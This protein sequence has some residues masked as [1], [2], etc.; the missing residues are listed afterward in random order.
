LE[1][2]QQLMG[3]STGNPYRALQSDLSKIQA[4]TRVPRTRMSRQFDDPGRGLTVFRLRI[5]QAAPFFLATVHLPSRLYWDADD[6]ALEATVVASALGQVEQ[7]AGHSRTVVVGD[8]NMNP[9]DAG[10]CG[11]HGLNA[12]MT[13]QVAMREVRVVQNRSYAYFYNPMWGLFGDRTPGPA[14]TFYLSSSKPVNY[15]WHMLDQ[16]LVRPAMINEFDD[17]QILDT[18][19][20]RSLLTTSGSPDSTLASD[21]LPLL[22]T[23]SV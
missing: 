17:V 5:G 15:H 13:R 9:F 10:M 6:Q 22:V 16:V 19:G 7:R 1:T 12:T 8:F 18:D 23:L 2:V 11:A 20:T 3:D 21:H 4:I 14:G